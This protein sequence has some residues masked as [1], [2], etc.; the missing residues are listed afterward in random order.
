[1][2]QLS[3]EKGITRLLDG[4]YPIKY[5]A[6]NCTNYSRQTYQNTRKVVSISRPD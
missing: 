4:R 6:T 2:E 1:M 3:S 5:L